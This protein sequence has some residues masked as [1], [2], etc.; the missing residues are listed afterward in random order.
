MV[1]GLK[2]KGELIIEAVAVERVNKHTYP[3]TGFNYK[4]IF[5][6]IANFIVK[7][8]HPRMYCMLGLRYFG[9]SPKLL[10]MFYYILIESVLLYC[11]VY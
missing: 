5:E 8:C 3:G 9:V 2:K 11:L 7:K 6:C 4:V 10:Y 1:V